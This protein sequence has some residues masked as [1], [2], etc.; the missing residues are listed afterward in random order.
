MQE[1]ERIVGVLP[2]CIE[3]DDEVDG[4]VA[5]RDAFEALTELAKAGRGLDEGQF[6]GRR[7]Q[8][9]A[10]VGGVVAVARGVDADADA[11]ARGWA[12]RACWRT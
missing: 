11:D 4:A 3:A 8:V 1:V 2:R 10:Q 7:L 9:V 12:G 5:L 6:I